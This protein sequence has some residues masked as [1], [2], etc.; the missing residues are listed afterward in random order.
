V[1]KGGPDGGDG[2]GGGDVILRANGHRYDLSHLAGRRL[3]AAGPGNPGGPNRL[4][5][6]GGT[7]LHIDVPLGTTALDAATQAVLAD[8]VAHDQREVIAR[9]GRG[10]VGTARLATPTHRTP[11]EGQAGQPGEERTII[12]RLSLMVDIAMVGPPNCGRSTLLSVLTKARPRI[13]EWPFS[14]T[15]P[16]LGALLTPTFEPLVMAELPALVAGSSQGK[17]LGNGFLVHAERAALLLVV[18]RGGASAADEIRMVRDELARGDAGLAA[19]PWIL[20]PTVEAV[21]GVPDSEQLPGWTAARD[22]TRFLTLLV[23]TWRRA[24]AG[25]P[26]S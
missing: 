16:V 14:T 21:P 4:F 20:C 25:Q 11:R 7:P 24:K 18:V 2:G 8:M 17:G 26:L 3:F 22:T 13:E 15:A 9:G 5:G 10:G 6:P 1:P 19:K 12:L 23:D